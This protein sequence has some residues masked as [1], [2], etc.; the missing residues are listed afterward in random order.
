MYSGCI[1]MQIIA[2]NVYLYGTGYWCCMSKLWHGIQFETNDILRY[3]LMVHLSREGVLILCISQFKPYF[4]A[5][6]T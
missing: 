6:G 1:S 5:A 4:I 3:S 2:K